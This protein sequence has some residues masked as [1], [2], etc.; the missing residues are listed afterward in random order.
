VSEKPSPFR[1]R[2]WAAVYRILS[3]VA[4]AVPA[5]RRADPPET[6]WKG[7][8]SDEK[9]F[10]VLRPILARF[11]PCTGKKKHARKDWLHARCERCDFHWPLWDADTH[12]VEKRR[13]PLCGDPGPTAGAN[14]IHPDLALWVNQLDG[15]ESDWR[16]RR[17]LTRAKAE[18]EAKKKK[19]K[20]YTQTYYED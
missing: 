10:A 1:E 13:C 6:P 18:R 3:R 4:S 8:Y 7:R 20:T 2:D 15:G 16:N 9:R 14:P 11:E 17:A 5:Y 12:D 19:S